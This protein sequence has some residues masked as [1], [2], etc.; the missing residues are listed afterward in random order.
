MRAD[1]LIS[2][3]MLLQTNGRMTAQALSDKLEVSTRTIY[4]D[5]DAL[6][7][8]GVPVYAERGPM[9]GCML[10]ESYR[11]NLTGLNES[12]VRALFAFS[13]PGLLA[14]LG[15]DKASEA[16][17]LKLTASLPAP[18]Q[19]DAS[20]VQERL[21][22]DPA[23][24]FH[25]EEPVPHLRLLQDAVWQ[26]RRVK[27][28]YRRSDGQWVKRLVSPLGL[29]AKASV[30]Y[31]VGGIQGEMIMVYRV[32]RVQEA[33][34]TDGRFTHPKPF[35]LKEFWQNWSTRFEKSQDVYG[36]ILQVL[37]TA[38]P[39]LVR[40]FGEGI[41]H[42]VTAA[43]TQAEDGSVLI[44]LTFGSAEDACQQLLGLGTAVKV[45]SPLELID[46]LTE[47]SRQILIAY[48]QPRQP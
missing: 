34:M 32:S 47:K 36:V 9:G 11:T 20:K 25:P 28:T 42:L 37:P 10:M 26:E 45:I 38:V 30:W 2:M 27:M 23:P 8:S 4:R 17:M 14:D 1:R 48:S 19:Q 43:E 31:L 40:Q 6:S 39:T 13:V 16:A 3:L 18:F 12:E 29:V 15:A 35:S 33:A 7:A 5:L 21:Y 24:W 46:H 22:L 44:E 41:V